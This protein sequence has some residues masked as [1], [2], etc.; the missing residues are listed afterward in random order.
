MFFP[1][2]FFHSQ[3]DGLPGK[4]P[5]PWRGTRLQFP[6]GQDPYEMHG[7][8]KDCLS[9]QLPVFGTMEQHLMYSNH[10]AIWR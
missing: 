3:D 5:A 1:R 4:P 2:F 7:K 8:S 6:A 9:P 10:P